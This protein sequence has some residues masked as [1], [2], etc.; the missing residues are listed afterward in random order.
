MT[1]RMECVRGSDRTLACRDTSVSGSVRWRGRCE[2]AVVS[3]VDGSMTAMAS[4]SDRRI[5]NWTQ[6]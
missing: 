2:L 5:G 1:W 4:E 6:V 3:E